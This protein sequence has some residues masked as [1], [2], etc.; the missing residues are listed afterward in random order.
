MTRRQ[1]DYCVESKHDA[2]LQKKVGW[3]TIGP[4]ASYSRTVEADRELRWVCFVLTMLA[5]A[6]SLR[7]GP[8]PL[9]FLLYLG[10]TLV[11]VAGVLMTR[12]LR[13]V[14]YTALPAPGLNIL[15]LD[16][17][18]HDSIISEIETRRKSA[19]LKATEPTPDL[20]IRAWLRRSRWL[21]ENDVLTRDEFLHRQRLALPD[22]S[23][24]LLAPEA[25]GM[26]PQ[27]FVQRKLGA[28]LIIELQP[29]RLTYTR[30]TWFN[31]AESFSVFY[32]DLQAPSVFH[33][34]DHQYEL[35][36]VLL[37]WIGIGVFGWMSAVSQAHPA[38][39]YVG[40]VGLQRAISDYG[41]ALLALVAAC[42]ILP[43]L[44]RLKCARPYPGIVLLRDK[45]YEAL[46][47]AIEERRI[48]VQRQ[49]A[50]PDPLLTLDEQ[51]QMLDEL[52][53]ADT[54]SDDEYRHFAARAV[55]VC[56]NPDL[57]VPMV[58]VDMSEKPRVMH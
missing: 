40:G 51:L 39:Y 31:G 11:M 50:E 8:Q 34:N 57:D 45:Q 42:A 46:L 30:A 44:T 56:D 28:R 29:D 5:A 27:R 35:L 33:E 3:D 2:T 12:R 55:E 49:F 17:R 41:P 22:M 20:T 15:V 25:G 47:A 23:R 21:A 10:M 16:E 13:C 19:L 1:L 14:G 36:I 48:A 32:R 18:Q 38:G 7:G 52:R 54:I 24:P 37:G 4:R 6:A 53:E 9:T 43:P 58:D 26:Q